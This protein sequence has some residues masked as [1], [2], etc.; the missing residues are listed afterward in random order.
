MLSIHLVRFRPTRTVSISGKQYGLI[1]VD[2]Y[3][4]WTWVKF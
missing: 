4:R 1:I 2:D 3:S